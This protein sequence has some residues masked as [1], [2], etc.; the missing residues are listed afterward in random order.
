[1]PRCLLRSQVFS[2]AHHS[3]LNFPRCTD[4]P[5]PVFAGPPRA[6]LARVR[7]PPGIPIQNDPLRSGPAPAPRRLPAV[8]PTAA[9]GRSLSPLIHA[10]RPP[11]PRPAPPR[12]PRPDVT[13]ALFARAFSI[14][15]AK[16]FVGTLSELRTALDRHGDHHALPSPCCN[17]NLW[18]T[19][20]HALAASRTKSGCPSRVRSAGRQDQASATAPTRKRKSR[21]PCSPRVSLCSR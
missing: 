14:Q 10:T 12:V 11:W 9:P 1:M 19:R 6:A 20:I 16:N 3:L 7:F 8:P 5:R 15:I 4:P 2:F 21:R 17:W 13:T 18:K